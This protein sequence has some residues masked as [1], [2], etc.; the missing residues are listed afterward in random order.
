[1]DA[2]TRSALAA[3]SYVHWGVIQISVANLIVIGLML[4]L[5]LAALLV[6]FPAPRR[7][8]PPSA[9]PMTDSLGN[10]SSFGDS[11]DRGGRDDDQG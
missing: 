4:V 11:S 1:M 3:G 9:G 10:S 2:A 7:T 8:F 5:F 6:P